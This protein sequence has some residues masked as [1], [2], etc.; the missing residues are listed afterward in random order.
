MRRE[1]VLLARIPQTGDQE[2]A[3]LLLLALVLVLV[4][5]VGFVFLLALLDDF[6]LGAA[7]AATSGAGSVPRRERNDMRDHLVAGLTSFIVA[8]NFQAAGAL[9][10]ARSSTP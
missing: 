4:L 10:L 6:G 9:A 1:G 2:H 7:G 5:V 3:T 8:L